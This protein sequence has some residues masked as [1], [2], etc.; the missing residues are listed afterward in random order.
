MAEANEKLAQWGLRLSDFGFYIVHCAGIKRYAADAA[1]HL[2][3]KIGE[4]LILNDQYSVINPPPAILTCA[5]QTEIPDF[6][7]IE[8]P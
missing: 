7:L 1:S 8:V 2:K 5:P 6:K 3:T 4:K